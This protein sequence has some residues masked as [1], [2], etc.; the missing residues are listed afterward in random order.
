MIPLNI[1]QIWIQGE[2]YIPEKFKE[3]IK[4]NK[5]M[6]PEFN[7]KIWD[8]IDILNLIKNDPEYIKTYYTLQYLHQKADFGRYIIL[9]K[10]GG[11]YID[12]DAKTHKPLINLIKELS[13][14]DFIVSKVDTDLIESYIVC[15]NKYCINNGVIFSAPGSKM[16]KE[17]INKVID[18]PSCGSLDMKLS[19]IHKTTG[20]T[21]FSDTIFMKNNEKVKI[22]NSEYLEPCKQDICN[23]TENTYIIHKH[24]AT[25]IP[26]F[27]KKF[28]N[29][30]I[31]YKN[32]YYFVLL[33]LI[34]LVLWQRKNIFG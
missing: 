16:I 29:N 5:E 33:T 2:K 28:M 32:R 27:I 19:C 34:L 9:D 8:E 7:Y 21:M 30:Y 18:N 4:I 31:R 6:N 26:D 25:W 11:I 13:N 3:N 22:L 12:M 10:I 20:P 15:G 17:I 24:E 1:H 23:I 14:Y